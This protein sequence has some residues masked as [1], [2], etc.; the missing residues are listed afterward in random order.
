MA[1]DAWFIGMGDYLD[2]ASPSNRAAWKALYKYDSVEKMMHE[3]MLEE[4]DKLFDILKPTKD[5]W[6]GML[7]GH[8]YWE[9]ED[10]SNTDINLCKRLGTKHLGDCAMVRLQFERPEH[11]ESVSC[12]I[13]CHHGDGSGNGVGAPLSRL[14]KA[15]EWVEAD[16][17]LMGHHHKLVSAPIPRFYLTSGK[18]PLLIAREKRLVATGSYLKGYMQGSKNVG[19]TAKGTYIEKKM[20]TPVALGSPTVTVTPRKY[21]RQGHTIRDIKMKVLA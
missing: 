16:L 7:S 15:V 2:V 5:R 9:F 11:K 8:H 13:W 3:K 10:G 17:Y 19:G 21:E 4:E 14:E 18:E 20:L 1:N 6:L 12:V